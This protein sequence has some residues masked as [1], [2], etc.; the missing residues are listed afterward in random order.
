MA[1]YFDPSLANNNGTL[2]LFQRSSPAVQAGV[3]NRF[4]L[5]RDQALRELAAEQR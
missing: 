3:I 4:N 5:E 1:I 2:M